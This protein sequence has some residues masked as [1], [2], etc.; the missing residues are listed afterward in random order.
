M[1]EKL[2]MSAKFWHLDVRVSHLLLSK[3]P[4]P[5]PQ[6]DTASYLHDAKLCI[7]GLYLVHCRMK[8]IKQLNEAK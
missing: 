5:G 2:Y 6:P 1:Y 3:R 8:A 4:K 7:S